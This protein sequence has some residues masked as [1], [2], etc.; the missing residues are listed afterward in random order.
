M[1]ARQIVKELVQKIIEADSNIKKD[2]DY[3]RGFGD[4]FNGKP[5]AAGQSAAYNAGY[6]DGNELPVGRPDKTKTTFGKR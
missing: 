1:D 5:K 2:P 6:D 3:K 4:A